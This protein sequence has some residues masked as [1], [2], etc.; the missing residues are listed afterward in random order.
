MRA[1]LPPS[2]KKRFARLEGI[3]K[4]NRAGRQLFDTGISIIVLRSGRRITFLRERKIRYIHRSLQ[5]LLLKRIYPDYILPLKKMKEEN[6]E[7]NV[8][9]MGCLASHLP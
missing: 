7:G 6:Y 3:R 5:V 2:R 1:L 4:K 8:F 9:N